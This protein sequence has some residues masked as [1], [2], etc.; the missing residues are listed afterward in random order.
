MR[1][2]DAAIPCVASVIAIWAI[3]TFSITEEKAHDIREELE[4]RR[5][6]P[7]APAAAPA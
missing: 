7:D 1:I 3:A 6:T 2:F 5:G 4:R